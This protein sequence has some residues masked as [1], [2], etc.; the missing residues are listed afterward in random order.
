MSSIPNLLLDTKVLA[1]DATANDFFPED[2]TL[3]GSFR[4]IGSTPLGRGRFADVY[5]VKSKTDER[6]YAIKR[7][8]MAFWCCKD[9][10]IALVEVQV[11]SE[12][13]KDHPLSPYLLR[14]FKAWQQDGHLHILTELCCRNTSRQLLDKS[15]R[16][17]PIC[18]VWKLL[19]NVASGLAHMHSRDW[20]H[21][22]IKPSNILLLADANLG[23]IFKIGD[24]GVARKAGSA[25]DGR[26]GDQKYMARELLQDT[27]KLVASADIFSLGLTI[28]EAA[29]VMEVPSEGSLWQSLR[30]GTQEVFT[31]DENESDLN[32]LIQKMMDPDPTK[33]VDANSI[34]NKRE[35]QEAETSHSSFL[36]YFIERFEEPTVTNEEDDE[37][38]TQHNTLSLCTPPPNIGA[39]FSF[40]TPQA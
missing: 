4:I 1:Y 22:D 7:R 14:F 32:P 19:H 23:A 38:Q 28:Y 8:R 18:L 34:L 29:S 30:N 11:M 21:N 9:R 40:S 13:Q 5:K 24:F 20:I 16:P 35:V 25:V 2:M 10:D 15:S 37:L 3:S 12:L 33:R 17:L 6:F 39:V 27:T 36:T 31:Y 26:E